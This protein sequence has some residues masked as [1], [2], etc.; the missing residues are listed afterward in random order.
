MH[1]LVRYVSSLICMHNWERQELTVERQ[2]PISGK[3]I[4]KDIRVHAK[5]TRCPAHH[6]YSKFGRIRGPFQHL[7][8]S[9]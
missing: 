8:M 2:H 9:R 1:R 3:V 5:C 4:D 6:N 7:R